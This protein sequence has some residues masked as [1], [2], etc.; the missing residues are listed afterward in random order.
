LSY[1]RHQFDV[2]KTT[3]AAGAVPESYYKY[4]FVIEC[5]PGTTS[6][7]IPDGVSD[8]EIA[9]SNAIVTKLLGWES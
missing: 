1:D 3:F 4:Y 8:L 7:E 9:T 2:T 6:V 5:L